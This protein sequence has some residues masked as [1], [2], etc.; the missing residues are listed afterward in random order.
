MCILYNTMSSFNVYCIICGNP[1]RKMNNEYEEEIN[2]YIATK[3]K[4]CMIMSL[5]M[6]LV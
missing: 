3:K 1:C 2:H 5:F 6:K 4:G